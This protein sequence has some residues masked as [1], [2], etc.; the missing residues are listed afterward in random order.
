MLPRSSSSRSSDRSGRTALVL[1]LAFL[2]TLPGVTRR[3]YASD[4]IQYFAY[5]RSLW[6]DHDL[7]FEN[8]YRYFYDTG[9]ARNELFRETFLERTTETGRRLNFGTIGSALLWAPFYGAAD[10]GVR[11]MG[12]AGRAVT[13][14]GFGRP[15]VAAICYGSAIY[16]FL[17]LL[18]SAAAARRVLALRGTPDAGAAS[19]ALVAAWLGT[20]LLF[21]MYVA[22]GMSHAPAAFAVAAF[23]A[24]WLRVRERWSAKGL[25]LLGALAA[26]MAMVREQDA[27]FALGPALDFAGYLLRPGVAARDRLR[28]AVRALA[29]GAAFAV[30]YLPQAASYLVL[31]GHLGPSRLVSRKMS[32]SSPHALQVLFSP[33][34]GFVFWTPLAVVAGL[35]LVMLLRAPRGT[36]DPGPDADPHVTRLGWA[37][38]AMGASQVYVAG[39]VESWTVA[40]AFGQ[41]RFVD[42]TV[43]L[44][45]GLAMVAWRLRGRA[46]RAGLALAVA[47]TLWWNISLMIQFGA[48]L[49]D[50][51]A[52]NL[53]RNLYNSVVT[54]PRRLPEIAY[55]Y[56]FRRE[57]FY[58]GS[59]PADHRP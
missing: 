55:R 6:F 28:P 42:L 17:A 56:M 45:I 20:P 22:P 2:A 46:G 50:R 12:A 57:S 32:W 33:E 35:G 15:Y 11:A 5:L 58:R 41:R 30:A 13:I 16:G 38:A 14:D 26:L 29:G 18:L 52:L 7:S 9:V 44:V 39:A 19:A 49:M 43:L 36:G 54:V 24:V 40:G 3:I 53:R 59:Q 48:G 37:L 21:Y 10:L 4:E 51:Q 47:L 1:V 27:F 31:N 34:H 25:A 8:E 23:V